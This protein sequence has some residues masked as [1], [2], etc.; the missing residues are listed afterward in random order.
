MFH[1]LTCHVA[2]L[3]IAAL[4]FTWK[5]RT[6]KTQLRRSVLRQRVAY[7]LWNAAQRA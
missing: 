3:A 2:V 6:T 5:D 1:M 7:M 4:Y